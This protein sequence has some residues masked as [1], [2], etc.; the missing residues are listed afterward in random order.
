[1]KDLVNL[2][3][4]R[5]GFPTIE[6]TPSAYQDLTFEKL[7]I[8]Y[9]AKG[10][11]LNPDTFKKNLELLTEDGKYNILAQLLSD[12]SQMPIRFAIFSG[13]T[14]ADGLY[15]VREFGYQCLLYSLDEILRYG[16][17]LN[18]IQADETHRIVERK[19]VPLF[20]NEAFREAIINAFVHNAWVKANEPMFTVFSDRIEILSRGT[21]APEQT[22]EGF[23]AGE[24]VPVNRKLSEIFLQLHISEKT[25]RGVPKITELYGK[26]AY[27]FRENSIVVT[28]PFKWINV[29][30]DRN[31]DKMGGQKDNKK[32]ERG[33][34]KAGG[35][36]INEMEEQAG[37]S[38]GNQ[39]AHLNESQRRILEQI[40]NNPNITKPQIAAALGLGKTTVDNGISALKRKG[41]IERVGSNKT[42]WWKI[43]P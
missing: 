4:E 15:S 37:W 16:D 34:Y 14:K 24:S 7:F 42:G 12:N 17:V 20:E 36:V 6:N 21:L 29:M 39:S 3:E 1:M 35:Y 11:K 5:H 19:E 41:Y 32:D 25:G 2:I 18:I 38:K 13:K 9:G 33:G 8:Y 30:G 22:I 40:R 23:F 26:E 43:V 31:H 27:D 10:L 28:I